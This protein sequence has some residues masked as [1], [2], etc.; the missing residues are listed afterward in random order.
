MGFPNVPSV[1]TVLELPVGEIDTGEEDESKLSDELPVRVNEDPGIC[2]EVTSKDVV[3]RELVAVLETAKVWL[4]DVPTDRTETDIEV[5]RTVKLSLSEIVLDPVSRE[6]TLAPAVLS[7]G[8]EE[9][10]DEL[11]VPLADIESSTDEL[12]VKLFV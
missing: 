12:R 10:P 4:S 9:S 6:V 1:G 8:R 5:L 3:S 7:P 2:V 11:T